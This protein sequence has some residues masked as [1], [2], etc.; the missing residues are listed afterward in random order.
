MSSSIPTSSIFRFKKAWLHNSTFLPSVLLAWQ[1]AST[2]SDSAGMLAL[3]LKATRAAAKAWSWCN[4]APPQLIPNCKF[5]LELLDFF[6]EQR[7]LSS[8]ETQVRRQCQDRLALAIKERAAYWK[9]RSK[10]RAIREVDAN[11]AFHHAQA[12]VRLRSNKIRMVECDGHQ[13][14]S[15]DGKIAHSPTSSLASLV[16]QGSPHGTST[17]LIC[18][19]TLAPCLTH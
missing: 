16:N 6:E 15:H 2:H 5:V 11:T 7:P 18:T 14:T 10:S 4:R 17:C 9:Q 8:D 13:I 3:C 1:V 12:T 19:R